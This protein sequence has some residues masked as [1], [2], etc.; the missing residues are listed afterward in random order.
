MVSDHTKVTQKLKR[1]I[2]VRHFQT[3]LAQD[4]FAQDLLIGIQL[5][6]DGPMVQNFFVGVLNSHFDVHNMVF[7]TALI[8]NFFLPKY[9]TSWD[10]FDMW[11]FCWLENAPWKNQ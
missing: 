11:T 5:C 8:D 3:K 6:T 2:P 10:D 7:E 9:K 1:H 4:P